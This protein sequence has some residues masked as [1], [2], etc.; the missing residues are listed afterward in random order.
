MPTYHFDFAPIWVHRHL[1]ITGL[2]HTIAVSVAA[3][4]IA[5]LLGTFIGTIA[6]SRAR[7]W[8]LAAMA[9]VEM[10]RNVPLLIH[11]YLWY[12]GLAFLRLPPVLC[13]VLGLAIYSAAYIAEIVRAGIAAVP[14]GQSE[15]AL[16]L[17][18]SR[19]TA[20]RLIVY[21]QALRI[22]AP[23]LASLFSQLIKDSS[24]ASVI[25]V[26]EL[27]FA[28][29]AI[30]SETFRSFEIYITVALL[31]LALVTVVSRLVL[32]FPGAHRPALRIGFADA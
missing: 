19:G 28:A 11:L 24:L 31:Y 23:S 2:A 10:A 17:G 4:A 14:C 30:D 27:S 8:R 32:L 12:V 6:A 20:L 13:A 29:S 26:S 15:A 1:L 16:A 9:F 22:I 18:L 25:T 7:A 21:P 5:L 3:L